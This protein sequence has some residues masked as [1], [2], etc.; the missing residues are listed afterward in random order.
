MVPASEAKHDKNVSFDIGATTNSRKTWELVD[1]WVNNCLANHQHC[2]YSES[3]NFLPSRLL[4]IDNTGQPKSFRLITSSECPINTRYMTL[5]HCWGAKPIER[6]LR[7]LKST[8]KQLRDG[9]P[10]DGLPKTFREAVAVTTRFN[11]K[12][13]WIDC[14]CIY[15]DS[16]EDWRVEASTMQQVYR[17]SFLNISA[18]GASNDDE[19]LFHE[20][21]PAHIAPTIVQLKRKRDCEPEP[22]LFVLE[23]YGAWRLT[24]EMEPIVKRGWV[25]QERLLSPRVLHFGR[26][27]LFWE[28]RQQNACEIHPEYVY[29][30]A[31]VHEHHGDRENLE[32]AKKPHL[33]KQLL[34]VQQR[35]LVD[36]PYQQLFIDWNTVLHA[37]SACVLS[38]S[39]DKLVALSGLAND[40]KHAL[41]TLRPGPHRY[42][43]GLWEERLQEGLCWCVYSGSRPASYRAPS[44][45]WAS[46]D[47]KIVVE[48][49]TSLTT[50]S[51]SLL[52][53]CNAET[54]VLDG[55]ETGQVT[56]GRLFAKGSWTMVRVCGEIDDRHGIQRQLQ[57]FVHPVTREKAESENVSRWH[58]TAFYDTRD[59]TPDEMF[60]VPIRLL[61]LEKDLLVVSALLLARTGENNEEIYRRIGIIY[62]Y[63]ES[64]E[65]VR[66]F[67]AQFPMKSLVVV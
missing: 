12:F 39:N 11:I 54:D 51:I 25:I 10:I 29:H 33:W 59:E 45:S 16:P 47:G 44:W 57:H 9:L 30:F 48:S 14:L 58:P 34:D 64:T 21:N 7:L 18:L 56:G 32:K 17:H 49:I 61:P 66:E 31:N 65:I 1:K 15:Q 19:G 37:Y 36:D 28:C 38:V 23:K 55:Q 62:V 8:F 41:G 43:A 52:E 24:F 27:Q 13:F 35:V 6:K 46:L 2:N 42:L 20:R 50:E 4:A 26:K 67:F 60:C 5:S 40:I 3:P 53:E 22:Y 63:F